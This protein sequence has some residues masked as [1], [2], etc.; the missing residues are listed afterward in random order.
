MGE[1]LDKGSEL[2]EAAV[3]RSPD[4]SAELSRLIERVRLIDE[5]YR[6]R[7]GFPKESAFALDGARA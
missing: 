4:C 3:A 1:L 5:N 6:A 2:R 7:I